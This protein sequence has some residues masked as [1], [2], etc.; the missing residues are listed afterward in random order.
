MPRISRS[1]CRRRA[2]RQRGRSRRCDRCPPSSSVS[3]RLPTVNRAGTLSLFAIAALTAPPF[4]SLPRTPPGRHA[5]FLY[6]IG[7][8]PDWFILYHG[9]VDVFFADRQLADACASEKQAKRRFGALRAKRIGLRLQQLR[10][11]EDLADLRAVTTR[12]H[13]LHG[14]LAGMIALDLD[15]PYRL[16]VEPLLPP[17]H[18]SSEADW[19]SVTAVVI[20]DVIDYH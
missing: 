8:V 1:R 14:D 11:A 10:V 2:P 7:Y 6:R 13:A 4:P 16:V 19:A 18:D 17:T 20:R 5:L 3:F 15:G 12:V 9:S